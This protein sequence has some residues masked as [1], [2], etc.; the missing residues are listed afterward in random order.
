VRNCANAQKSARSRTREAVVSLLEGIPPRALGSAL[1]HI[2]WP[3]SYCSITLLEKRRGG[4]QR[5]NARKNAKAARRRR[6]LA[7]SLPTS[8]SIPDG[9]NRVEYSSRR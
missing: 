7:E 6:E 5:E 9:G 4:Q 2:F 1:P 8:Y 3:S